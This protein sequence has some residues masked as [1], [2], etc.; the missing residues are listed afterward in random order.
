MTQHTIDKE[1]KIKPGGLSFIML[2]VIVPSFF[3]ASYAE[4]H[5]TDGLYAECRLC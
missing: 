5:Y 2:N 1:H 4:F 3:Y